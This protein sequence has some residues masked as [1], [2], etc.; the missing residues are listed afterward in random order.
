V[1]LVDAIAFVVVKEDNVVLAT[2]LE[3]I[4]RELFDEI[5]GM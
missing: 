3:E 2:P 4:V 1:R 5:D